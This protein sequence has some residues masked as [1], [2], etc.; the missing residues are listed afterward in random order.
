MTIKQSSD[1]NLHHGNETLTYNQN[2][3]VK[4]T[5]LLTSDQHKIY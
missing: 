1:K 5:F 3:L 2:L 4:Y